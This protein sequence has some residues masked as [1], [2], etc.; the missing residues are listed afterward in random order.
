M[1][2]PVTN[3]GCFLHTLMNAYIE[4]D[5]FYYIRL[6]TTSSGM[7]FIEAVKFLQ[8]LKGLKYWKVDLYTL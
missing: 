3:E 4:T 5:A 8:D 6:Y 2:S 7:N 1:S